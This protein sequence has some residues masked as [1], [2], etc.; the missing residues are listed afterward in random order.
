MVVFCY[1]FCLQT[2]FWFNM[3]RLLQ[4]TYV[5][6]EVEILNLK[7]QKWEI[8]EEF[9]V[10]EKVRTYVY[11]CEMI[12]ISCFLFVLMRFNWQEATTEGQS[13][14][15]SPQMYVLLFSILMLLGFINISYDYYFAWCICLAPFINNF[16]AKDLY[17]ILLAYVRN[18]AFIIVKLFTVRKIMSYSFNSI[19]LR[20]SWICK[21]MLWE[22]N[23]FFR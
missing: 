18:D 23:T 20:F 6:G 11:W 13:E 21:Y 12:S 22:N 10:R 5:D 17:L 8:L 3:Y 15:A 16:L 14:E 7:T 2:G 19:I 4:V 1:S 9:S